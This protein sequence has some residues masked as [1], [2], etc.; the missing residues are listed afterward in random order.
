MLAAPASA[1]GRCGHHPWC[2][3][4]LS[5]DAR[6]SL[7]LKALTPS[8][9]IALLGGDDFEGGVNSSPTTHT[10]TSDGVPR[11]GL[12]T[13]YYSDGPV[14]P[15][16]GPSTGLPIPMAVAASFDP[17]MARLHAAVVGT[18]AR[19]KGNDVVFAPTVNIM[20][21][22]LGGRTFEGYGE[23][24]YLDTRTAVAWIRSLQARGV[25]GDVKHFAANNQE[26]RDPSGKS[27]GPETP[28]GAGSEGSRYFI[29]ANIDERT[30]REIYLP[31]FEAAV[32]DAHVGSVMCSY[33]KL[34][35]SYACENEHL[36]HRVLEHD[37][38]F[39]GYVIAD[40]GAAHDVV[41]SLNHGLDFEPWPPFAYR[42]DEIQAAVLTRQSSQ[43]Q[44]D[45]HVRR[46]LRTLFAFRF[47][48]RR[49]YRNDDRQIPKRRDA[50]IA[51]DV[52]R[53]GVTLLRNRGVLPLRARRL[54]SIAVIGQPATQ[55]VTGGGSANVTP[56][57]FVPPLRSIRAR[58]GRGVHVR[59]DDGSDQDSAAALAKRSDVAIVFA[60]DY[61]TEGVDRFCLSL[62]CPMVHGDQDGL[63][64]RVA[65]A[66]RRSVVV[67][68]TGGPVLTPWRRKVAGLLEAWYPGS[69]AGPALASVLFGDADPGG[70]LPAT[71]PRREAD[72]PTAGDPEKYPG[73]DNE[74]TY[75]E[76]VLVG[77]RWYDA[78][79]LE[80]AFPFGF[81]LSYTR[82]RYRRLHVAARRHG[83]GAA[84]SVRI[85]NVGRRRGSDVAQLYLHLPS[86]RPGVVQ[87]PHQLR[88][89]RKVRL[90]RGAHRT[91]RFRLGARAFSYWDVRSRGWRVAPGCYRVLVGRSSRS[92]P[93]RR[94]L[95]V[96]GASCGAHAVRV[97]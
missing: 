30:L 83:V 95:A 71:F 16:Q 45:A 13:T 72:T 90:R 87:P 1:A 59:Y 6:A 7:L 24:P 75:K 57:S 74:E 21:T 9:R 28:L 56:F 37:W 8:E 67:L 34:N 43:R 17:A 31:H 82:F 5:P 73:V 60:A 14:G 78:R 62:E 20:R 86:P 64:R 55:F 70:R 46:V 27:G 58:A 44:V 47:F 4:S 77:Y 22:P 32:K 97:G 39:K 91:V 3:T 68:E 94:T 93:L 85:A 38:R 52:E 19:D 76:G 36:L 66:N 81:G 33:N 80:P 29:D 18:E 50:R 88:G 42:P 49:A 92:L 12:P 15:R 35:G 61:E 2:D 54:H 96:R 69:R 40:Y 26:G 79:R 53:A 41:A 89:F 10:G 48:D 25:I 65:A 51:R 23:D 63:I 11:V 84:V